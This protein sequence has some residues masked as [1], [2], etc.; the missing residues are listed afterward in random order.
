MRRKPRPAPRPAPYRSS[1]GVRALLAFIAATALLASQGLSVLHFV[2][3]PHHLCEVHGTLED[4]A[5]KAHQ[6]DAS[7]NRERAAA[8]AADSSVDGHEAC[9]VA[10]LS[11]HGAALPRAVTQA[12]LL[13]GDVVALESGPSGVEAD[14]AAILARAPK[15]SPP[16]IA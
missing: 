3:V 12:A 15:L 9:T 6:A 10:A 7:A 1:V 8:Q 5:V 2:L 13:G 16:R 14:R 11:K 4:G